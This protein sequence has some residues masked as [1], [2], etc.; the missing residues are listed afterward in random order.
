[1]AA[2]GAQHL[3]RSPQSIDSPWSAYQHKPGEVDAGSGESGCIREI[4]RCKPYDALARPGKPGQRRQQE[5]QLT[6]A[7]VPG[8][9]L[10]QRASRPAAPGKLAVERVEAGRRD[11]CTGGDRPAAPDWMPFEDLL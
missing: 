7:G 3:L 1:M 5:L 8:E 9:K 11:G 2:C 6:D 4:R 10:G